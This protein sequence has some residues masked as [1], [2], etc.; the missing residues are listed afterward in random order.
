MLQAT[1]L[2]CTRAKIQGV[3]VKIVIRPVEES[4]LLE[5]ERIFDLWKFRLNNE[6][7]FAEHENSRLIWLVADVDGEPLA[8]VW[9]ELFPEHDRSGRTLHVV[10]FRVHESIRRRGIG[11]ALLAALEKEGV[12]RGRQEATLF[13]AQDNRP[14]QNLYKKA[15]Y[16]VVDIR[17]ARWEFQDPAGNTHLITEDQ[18]VMHKILVSESIARTQR[19]GVK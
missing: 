17:F 18:F 1:P 4:D 10:A 14:A 7:A 12:K 5:I 19:Y 15:G 6:R 13:V 2:R 11:T 3:N 9:G 8:S 16:R